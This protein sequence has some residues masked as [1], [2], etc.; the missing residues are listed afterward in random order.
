MASAV[1]EGA[2]I[3]LG[4]DRAVGRRRRRRPPAGRG[5]AQGPGRRAE[6]GPG[7]DQGRLRGTGEGRRQRARRADRPRHPAAAA[8][9]DRRRG[10]WRSSPPRPT[11]WWPSTVRRSWCPAATTASSRCAYDREAQERR[12]QQAQRQLDQLGKVN[13]LALEEFAA[14]EERHAFLVAQ[15]EDLKKT[16][17]DLL[18]V[19]REVDERVQQVFTAAYADVAREFEAIIGR[20]FPGG[21]GRLVL[22]DP[23]DM[24]PPASTSRRGRR[25]RRSSGCRCCPAGSGR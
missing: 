8:G 25:A 14:L 18:T 2:R 1:A 9:A 24:L 6:G 22:T 11:C 17:R 5:G 20:L 10:R 23:D 4:P 19:I 16:R 21:E 3:A 15:L 7:P 12:A 13:P